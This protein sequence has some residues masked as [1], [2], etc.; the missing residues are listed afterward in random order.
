MDE[1]KREREISDLYLIAAFFAY[2]IR[3]IRIDRH[4]PN[5]QKFV[6]DAEQKI[7]VR[8]SENGEALLRELTVEEIEL[9]FLVDN[10]WLP[11]NYPKALKDTRA[12]I[13][14]YREDHY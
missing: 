6:F 9:Y 5:R 2:G 10:L 13:H 8:V 11:G 4:N 3:A 7:P 14:G 12:T 1:Q